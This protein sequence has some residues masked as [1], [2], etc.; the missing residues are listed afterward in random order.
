MTNLPRNPHQEEKMSTVKRCTASILV[1]SGILYAAPAVAAGE[2]GSFSSVA[3]LVYDY[4]TLEH[5]DLD[6]PRSGGQLMTFA[7]VVM[8]ETSA[9]WHTGATPA[10]GRDRGISI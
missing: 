6:L 9:A 10:S 8:G 1:A 7:G 3:S 4:T 5:A 2:S